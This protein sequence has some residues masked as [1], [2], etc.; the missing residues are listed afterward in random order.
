MNTRLAPFDNVEI[1]RAVAAAVDREQPAMLD[2][3][4]VSPMTQL[5]PRGVPGYD[6]SFSG[7]RHDEAAALGHMARAGYPY[8]P[9]TGKGGWP[10]PIVYTVQDR[11]FNSYW[12]QVL[13]QQLARIGLRLELRLV[14]QPAYLALTQRAG[15]SQM[16]TQGWSAD[17]A[18]PSTFFD[19][20]FTSAAIKPEGTNNTAFY[21]N[22]RYDAL[23]ARARRSVDAA[24]GRALYREA[25][26]I[27]CDEAPW[28]FS[29]GQHDAVMRQPY[30]H[31]FAAHPVWP[32]DVRRVWLDRAGASLPRALT[33]GLP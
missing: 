15:A 28:A 14:T 5:L 23:V 26:E 18:E 3:V 31:G 17:Y 4:H 2:R 10:H 30:V 8:D 16:S 29:F 24:V 7:Q 12:S 32:F 9:V 20:L 6:P 21:E 33:G 27:L 22:P 1:R 25:N 11:T 13:Q 19:P